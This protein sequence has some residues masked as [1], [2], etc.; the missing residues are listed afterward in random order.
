MKLSFAYKLWIPLVVALLSLAGS[1]FFGSVK[2]KDDQLA[3]REKELIYVSQLALNVVK[4]QAALVDKGLI[5]KEEAQGRAIQ[6]IKDLRY[7]ESGYF[8]ILDTRAQVQLALQEQQQL[9]IPHYLLSQEA[10]LLLLLH[11]LLLQKQ[12]IHIV[13]LVQ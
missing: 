5:S 12:T 13:R 1:L 8:T 3:L 4:T 9:Q 2:I 7:G 11:K 10:E 6:I